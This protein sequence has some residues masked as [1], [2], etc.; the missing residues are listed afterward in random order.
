MEFFKK[1]LL[2]LALFSAL[3][4]AGVGCKDNNN[5]EDA[6]DEIGEVVEDAGD[7]VKDATN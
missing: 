2:V 7:A 1:L 5:L 6:G 4:I 3:S